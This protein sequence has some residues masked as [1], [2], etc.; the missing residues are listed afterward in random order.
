MGCRGQSAVTHDMRYCD[1]GCNFVIHT[2]EHRK[3]QYILN[4][5]LHRLVWH[6]YILLIAVSSS[7]HCASVYWNCIVCEMLCQLSGS[8]SMLSASFLFLFKSRRVGSF[9]CLCDVF[10]IT[11]VVIS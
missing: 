6:S 1:E 10:L 3:P 5:C 4:T 9:F 7:H 2:N 11:L 8:A